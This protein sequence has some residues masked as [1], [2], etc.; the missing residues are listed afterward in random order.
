MAPS[1]RSAGPGGLLAEIDSARW[2]TLDQ[3]RR[4]HPAPP[5]ADAAPRLDLVDIILASGLGGRGGAGFPTGEK[6]RAV[7]SRPGPRT[8]VVNASEGEP[9]SAKDRL[10]LARAPHLVL[11]GALLAA[12]AVGADTIVVAVDRAHA[13]AMEGVR[14]AIVERRGE[15][16]GDGGSVDLRVAAAP[17][18]YVA[19]E[20]SALVRWLDGGPAKPTG[21][22]AYAGGQG[23]VGGRPTLVQNVE[24]LAHLAQI[25][26]YGPDWFAAAGTP[27]EPGTA[28]VTVSGAVRRPCVTEVPWGTPIEDL[29]GRAGGPTGQPQALLVGGFSGTWVPAAALAA[30]FS[31]AGLAPFGA[32][33]GAGVLV[34][35]PE[36][37]CGL[38]ETARVLQWF[39]DETAGQCGPC[40][41][42][43]PA[44]AGAVAALEWDGSRDSVARLRRWAD[45]IEGRGACRHPDGAVTLLRSALDVFASDLDDHAEGHG[46]PGAGHP[47]VLDVP[48]VGSEWR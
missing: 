38:A 15:G 33:P 3:H 18:R 43:L 30:P 13:A 19:G 9:A 24:T 39:A 4:R 37:A 28:L 32:A 36:G 10:L 22:H 12:A 27:A 40:V 45:D 5:P 35:L 16:E 14:R 7:A 46:C 17:T 29:L 34:A 6:L 11:D 31:R 26:R 2:T 23:G 47:P 20:S 42:G 48:A 44:L 25:L 8:V 1:I 41:R 21:A